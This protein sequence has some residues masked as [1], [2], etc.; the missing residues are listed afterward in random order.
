LDIDLDWSE[1]GAITGQSG[2]GQNNQNKPEKKGNITSSP[3]SP[4]PNLNHG[5]P[6]CL[7][8]GF[9][10]SWGKLKL[11]LKMSQLTNPP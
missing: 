11:I 9:C 4:T 2:D 8:A 6:A 5:E 7:A 1:I 10:L 3:V